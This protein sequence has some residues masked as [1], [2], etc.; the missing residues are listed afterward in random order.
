M[1]LGERKARQGELWVPMAVMA[2]HGAHPF[3]RRL[4]HILEQNRF[5][6][7]MEK[8]FAPFYSDRTGRPGIAPGVYGRMLMIGYFEGLDS[9]RG[10]AWRCADSMA[11]R[12][13]L[14]LGM[15]TGTPD[16]STI[17]GIRRKVS[18]EAHQAI[19]RWVLKVL[20]QTK[21]LKGQR[22][23]LD[24]TTLEANAAMRSI[25]R[26]DIGESYQAFL[27]ELA[28]SSGIETPTREDLARID[29]NRPRK[30]SNDDWKSP[31]DEDA[32]ITKMKDG[33]THLAHK[34]EH[35]VDLD[36][37]AVVAVTVQPANAG[38][39]QTMM[40]TLCD[41]VETV[42]TLEQKGVNTDAMLQAVVADKGYHSNE[43]LLQVQEL[44]MQSYIA[45]PDRGRRCWKGNRE[46][47]DAVYANRRRCRSARGGRLRRLR[48]E[49]V[50]RSFA[51]VYDTGGMRRVHLR[52]RDNI[53]K[54]VLVHI[55]G[56]NLSLILRKLY[57]AGTPRRFRD[58]YAA[59]WSWLLHRFTHG[60][61]VHTAFTLHQIV[62]LP[63]IPVRMVA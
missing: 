55:A 57:G 46:A 39:T 59:A 61:D 12:E 27:T 38:D 36:S 26:R 3:Y 9:E 51:H 53:L 52:G 17:S 10:I 20:S 35:A 23:G 24:A 16:H 29:R 48:A 41:T 14:G 30:G 44:T 6:S 8:L 11:L 37:G 13:F 56:F 43:S 60:N 33:R 25:V 50:E 54:R 49:R 58:A 63:E 31:T 42:R 34:A 40:A 15:T 28:H 19:F 32:R 45:E 7:F 1:A 62:P 21:L 4:N 2:G 5:D 47:Q 22:L 18:V